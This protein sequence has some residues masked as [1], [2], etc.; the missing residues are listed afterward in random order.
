MTESEVKLLKREIVTASIYYGR[1]LQDQVIAMYVEDL[2]YF[3]IEKVMFAIQVYRKNPKNRAM[4]LPAH[5][6]EIMCPE[7]K[8]ED[9]GV[10]LASRIIG[11]L[12]KY[13]Y[14]WS[15]GTYAGGQLVFA[16]KD[17]LQP[18][19][20]EAVKSEIGEAGWYVIDLLGGWSHVCE[21]DK[22][23]ETGI[24]QAQLRDLAKAILIKQK[25]GT[26]EEIS[27]TKENQEVITSVQNKLAMK[28][29]PVQEEPES[30]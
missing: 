18:S 6:I 15:M 3:D 23:G 27:W 4:F 11:C 28:I 20:Q 25:N 22:A 16:G 7:T 10:V 14:T 9:D 2:K 26:L 12:A 30:V 8:S 24:L 13:G 21:R 5:L 17:R 29:K 1:D 19:F